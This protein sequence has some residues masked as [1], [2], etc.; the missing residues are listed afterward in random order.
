MIYHSLS[1]HF[2][3]TLRNT[4]DFSCGLKILENKYFLCFLSI[5]CLFLQLATNSAP[6]SP[7][8]SVVFH[9]ISFREVI[10]GCGDLF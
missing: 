9:V 3:P 8:K 6:V 2:L 1:T 5:C 4:Y 10:L 7:V